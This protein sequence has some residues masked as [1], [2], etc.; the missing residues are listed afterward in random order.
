MEKYY[1]DLAKRNKLTIKQD[2][3][4]KVGFEGSEITLKIPEDE[5]IKEGWK[6]TPITYPMVC[7]CAHICS[8]NNSGAIRV[9]FYALV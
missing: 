1:S 6:I 9:L 7:L 3:L 5:E 4:T 8:D 2:R